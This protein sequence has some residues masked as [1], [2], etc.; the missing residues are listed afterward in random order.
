MEIIL[1]MRKIRSENKVSEDIK[2]INQI[3][4]NN[5]I[6]NNNFNRQ[7]T[8]SILLEHPNKENN[9]NHKSNPPPRF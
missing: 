3:N 2:I 8:K 1:I 7:N 5:D 4:D 9:S 6:D